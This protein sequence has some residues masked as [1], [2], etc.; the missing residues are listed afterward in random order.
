MFQ[1]DE[2]AVKEQLL[3]LIRRAATDL[4]DDVVDSIK[5]AQQNEDEGSRK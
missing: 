2:G 4:P 5:A 1:Y 3:E